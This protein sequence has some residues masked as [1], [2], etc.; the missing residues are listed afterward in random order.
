MIVK[1]SSI[2]DVKLADI[3]IKRPQSGVG[4]ITGEA[5]EYVSDLRIG[6]DRFPPASPPTKVDGADA[7]FHIS[8]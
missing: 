7:P 1:R 3:H 8:R 5:E 2:P 6:G 4:N